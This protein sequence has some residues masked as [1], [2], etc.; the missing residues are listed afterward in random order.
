MGD[1][2]VH[3]SLNQSLKQYDCD[4]AENKIVEQFVPINPELIN[5]CTNQN[6]MNE[7]EMNFQYIEAHDDEYLN[8]NF[9]I[10]EIVLNLKEINAKKVKQ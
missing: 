8:S 7:N 9:E 10:R 2:A 5:D 1:E 3:F 4:N 6:S